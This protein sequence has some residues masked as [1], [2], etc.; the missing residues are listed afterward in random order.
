[1][2]ETLAPGTGGLSNSIVIGCEISSVELLVTKPVVVPPENEATLCEK[3]VTLV[4]ACRP[5]VDVLLGLLRP[6]TTVLSGAKGAAFA[7]IDTFWS[8]L[9]GFENE[10]VWGE[11]E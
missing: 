3:I 11:K 9:P 6:R 8:K 1:L 2:T 10:T 5:I 7:V 4:L